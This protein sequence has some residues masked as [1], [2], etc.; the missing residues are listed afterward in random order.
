MDF[1]VLFALEFLGNSSRLFQVRTEIVTGLKLSVELLLP[2]DV[3]LLTL[4]KF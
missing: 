2:A 1:N 4:G 3:F